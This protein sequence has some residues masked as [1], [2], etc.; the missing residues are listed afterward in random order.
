MSGV[1]ATLDAVLDQSWL[2]HALDDLDRDGR[3]IDH[4]TFRRLGVI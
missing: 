3:I 4:D 2:R 1:P